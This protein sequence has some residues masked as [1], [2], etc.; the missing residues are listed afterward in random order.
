MTCQNSLELNPIGPR[1]NHRSHANHK[2]TA[3]KRCQNHI[4]DSRIHNATGVITIIS[5]YQGKVHVRSWTSYSTGKR[6]CRASMGKSQIW[7]ASKARCLGNVMAFCSI[8]IIYGLNR[9]Q[10]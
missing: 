10:N 8:L 1:D 2:Y 5:L 4:F 6:A 9:S 7:Q 3:L